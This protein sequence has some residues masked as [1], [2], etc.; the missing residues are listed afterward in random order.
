[1]ENR[2]SEKRSPA[3]GG[4]PAPARGVLRCKCKCRSSIRVGVALP[5]R[6]SRMKYVYGSGKQRDSELFI[7]EFMDDDFVY[8]GLV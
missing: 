8:L 5:Q 6:S 2:A 3:R 7:F 1:M 4:A